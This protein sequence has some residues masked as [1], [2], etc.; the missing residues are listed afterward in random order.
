MA[1]QPAEV[2]RALA[3]EMVSL[4]FGSPGKLRRYNPRILW[5]PVFI[6][7]LKYNFEFTKELSKHSALKNW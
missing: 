6:C 7:F 5:T 3:R 2:E 1:Y 4:S